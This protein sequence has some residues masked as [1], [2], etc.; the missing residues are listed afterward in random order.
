MPR[1]GTSTRTRILD[2]AQALVIARGFSA[3]TVDEII[4][5]AHASKGAFFNHFP[6]KQ[7]LA[8]ALVERYAAEDAA[9]LASLRERSERLSDD[10]LQ[11]LLLFL[12]LLADVTEESMGT[13]P[14]CLFA[15][16]CYERELVDEATQE[17]IAEALRLWG[18]TLRRQ[19][20]QIA[21][22]YPPRHPVDLD[23]LADLATTTIEGS[24]V[25]V[26]ALGDPALVR[27]QLDQLRAY[28]TLLFAA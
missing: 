2:A 24:Y 7:D 8:R 28:L 21:E 22:R 5:A 4:S 17:L 6:T 9:V 25:M 14:G 20:D 23:A 11:Q 16:F 15:S 27:G 1:D 3:S 26:R 12:G 10:P 19:L 13:T 18:R